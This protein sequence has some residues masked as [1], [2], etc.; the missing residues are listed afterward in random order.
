MSL[1][2]TF[3]EL[4]RFSEEYNALS[5]LLALFW[6]P[7]GKT[8]AEITEQAMREYAASWFEEIVID[9]QRFLNQQELPM[10]L[11][12]SGANRWLPTEPEERHWLQTL[13]D[14]VQAAL[15]ARKGAQDQ[16][17]A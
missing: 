9:G 4:R 11:I 15:E 16:K 7:D 8:D 12:S 6:D 14:R 17:Q 2:P 1:R 5:T 10:C 13:L 3:D